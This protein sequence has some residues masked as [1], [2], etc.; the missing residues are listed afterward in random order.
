MKIASDKKA[1]LTAWAGNRRQHTQLPRDTQQTFLS[2]FI[3]A[4]HSS[5]GPGS[6]WRE[7]R[8]M[9]TRA[10]L[11]W[12]FWGAGEDNETSHHST[13]ELG[14][15]HSLTSTEAASSEVCESSGEVFH[16]V[17]SLRSK[18]IGVGPH[19]Q[20]SWDAEQGKRGWGVGWGRVGV[21]GF[22]LPRSPAHQSVPIRSA[23]IWHLLS[24][25]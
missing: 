22:I 23:Q 15:Q 1:V 2:S 21:V 9:Y 25:P 3:H 13:V 19:V 7:E 16:L 24:S 10:L 18:R 20:N 4:I 17:S 8:G 6:G 5:T 11:W 14:I 12:R